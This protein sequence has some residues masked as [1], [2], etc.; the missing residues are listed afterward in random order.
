MINS[1][2]DFEI[3]EGSRYIGQG[4]FSKVLKCRLLKDGKIYGL[5]IVG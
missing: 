2:A 1:T 4:A 3:L 5:K